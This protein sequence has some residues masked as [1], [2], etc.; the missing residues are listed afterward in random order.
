MATLAIAH[1]ARW[2][3]C[4]AGLVNDGDAAE[5]AR[6]ALDAG[7]PFLQGDQGRM[8]RFWEAVA[9]LVASGVPLDVAIVDI[10]SHYS[11]RSDGRMPAVSGRS[12]GQDVDRNYEGGCPPV[13]D[14]SAGQ[15]LAGT[16]SGAGGVAD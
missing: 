14:E 15:R 13:A 8:A 4:T 7:G 6:L 10:E 3:N 9:R 1:E 2:K 5:F 16:V 12:A 11:S